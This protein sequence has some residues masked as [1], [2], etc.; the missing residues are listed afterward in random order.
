MI[1]LNDEVSALRESRQA[2]RQENTDA[3]VFV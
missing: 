3:F 2:D 1:R